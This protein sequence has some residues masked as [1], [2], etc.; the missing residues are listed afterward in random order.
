M[1]TAADAVQ[2]EDETG[3]A[4]EDEVRSGQRFEFGANWASFLKVLD[5]DRIAE[6][7][8]SLLDFLGGT[9]LEGQTFI[10]VGS[11]SGLFSLAARRLGAK[12]TSFD[13]DPNSV[14]CTRE[15]K[16]RYFDGDSDW[17]ILGQASVLDRAYVESLGTFDIVYSW[18]VLHH[19][20]HMWDA[21]DNVTTLVRPGGR[22]FIMIYMDRGRTSKAWHAI[23]RTYVS[24]RAGKIAVTA[25]MIPYYVGRTF[26]S[27]VLR[28]R[29][30]LDTYREHKRKR[31]MSRFHDWIDWIGG[32]PFEVASPEALQDFLGPRGFTLLKRD[33]QQYVFQRADTNEE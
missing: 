32:Y 5:E 27:D 1:T 8:R 9:D 21:I 14:A 17:N 19:T 25:T 26:A 4:F 30:P 23:K 15:L 2:D 18:G 31:G 33:Y 12:V 7:E 16:R 29:N 24:G 28:A 10:D 20:G 22:L 6:A 3:R 13:Y 11:G